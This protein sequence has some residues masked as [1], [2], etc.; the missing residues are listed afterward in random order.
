MNCKKCGKEIPEG[1][2]L[3][4]ECEKQ[5]ALESSSVIQPVTVGGEKKGLSKKTIGII[6]GVCVAVAIAI[7]ALI[8]VFSGAANGGNEESSVKEFYSFVRGEDGSEKLVLVTEV[9]P[10]TKNSNNKNNDN[11]AGKNNAD[12]Q[13]NNNQTTTKK[14]ET[15]PAQNP[16]KIGNEI[17][18]DEVKLDSKIQQSLTAFFSG[19]FYYDGVMYAEDGSAT[20]LKM[21]VNG[22]DLEA[23]MY[24][25]GMNINMGFM[26]LD[27]KTYI[28]NTDNK[29]YLEFTAELGEMFGIDMNDL[30]LGDLSKLFSAKKS[31]PDAQYSTTVNG[32]N[33]T[34]YEYVSEDKS[35]ST[36]F[37]F[38]GDE[39]VEMDQS[40]A[41][42][43]NESRT[44]ISQ[45]SYSIPSDM[46]TLNGLSPASSLMAMFP[47]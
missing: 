5:E 2:E 41:D 17:K 23:I 34:C 1:K 33:A 27:G 47:Q 44:M 21:A 8:L 19:K 29:Q 16:N 37:Y 28:V 36:K 12:N 26:Q 45:F 42:G 13:A 30:K 18:E 10:A 11:N 35:T 25:S 22:S 40:N 31:T 24:D 32:K 3:C 43:T 14:P 20:K 46:L 6:I 39:L 38:V 9:V 4:A 15:V 7:V